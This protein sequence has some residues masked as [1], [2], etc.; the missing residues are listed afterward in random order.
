M[1]TRI[2]ISSLLMLLSGWLGAQCPDCT[3]DEGC[4]SPDGF[5][6]I[7]PEV[8]PTAT[9][10]SYYEEVLTF[11]LP[12]EFT[13]PDSG[14][15]ATLNQVTITSVTGLPLG[16]DFTQ[17]S[18]D[19]I[20]YPADGDNLGCATLCGTPI[21]P[22]DYTITITAL[23]G[24]TVFGLPFTA[25]ES[26]TRPFTV[27]PGASGTA[28]FSASAVAGCGQLEVDFV[29]LVDGAPNPTAWSWDFGNG[30][31]SSDLAPPTQT[32]T[33]PGDYQV[34]LETVVSS[35]QLTELTLTS[36]ADGWAGDIEELTTGF[37]PD[38]YFVV[39]DGAGNP[40]YTSD[41]FVDQNE[42][43]WTGLAVDLPNPPYSI[44]VW[45]QDNGGLFG[46]SDD[47]L[48]TAPI[49]LTEGIQS[50]T[51]ADPAGS[52]GFATLALTPITVVNDT[53]DVQVFPLPELEML[54]Q[55]DTAYV[56]DPQVTGVLW[57]L[58][59]DTLEVDN[60]LAVPLS[61]W[62]VYQAEL[63]NS[64]GCTAWIEPLV[65]CPDFELTWDGEWLTAAP[66][67]AS[68]TWFFNG[69]EVEGETG[70]TL[71][72]T[73]PGNYAVTITTDYGCTYTPSIYT[74]SVGVDE[75]AHGLRV[76]PNPTQGW[77]HVELKTPAN[78][79]RLRT[80]TGAVVLEVAV[81]GTRHQLNLNGWTPGV[82][83]LEAETATGAVSSRVVV[84]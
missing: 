31:T 75:L 40:V 62:G 4:I 59:G 44:Q 79:L 56:L 46:S 18:P 15:P 23:V 39:L 11:F 76:F 9:A 19:G 7:C 47:N 32:Y 3:P 64:F 37:S 71:E 72:A 48:G 84:Q 34:T 70:N 1:N 29:A 51:S 5:P 2:V 30:N 12:A 14:I 58:N 74:V 17:S 13:D 52:N 33:T 24:T 67:M 69:L 22:G 65:Q 26:F 10:N 8:I 63:S 68:Y 50:F 28:S 80:L 81:P 60:P 16:I 66:G 35:W 42:G 25:T 27:V 41:A 77:L 21:L 54:L 6:T 55:D 53:V 43:T 45:D 78:V 36:L 49:T 61:G 73:T 57:L 83:L 20:Y 82:Y 38:P